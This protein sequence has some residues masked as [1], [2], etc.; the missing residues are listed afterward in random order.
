MGV[1]VYLRW[2]G[3]TAEEEAAQ[4]TGFST[5]SGHVG[6]LRESYSGPPMSGLVVL[7]PESWDDDG[8]VPAATLRE[9]LPAAL[10]AVKERYADWDRVDEAVKSYVDFVDLAERK[11]AESGEPCTVHISY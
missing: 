8:P 1:D 9:R 11:E 2:K 5:V 10:E 3:Q 7:F 6:Y 4:I